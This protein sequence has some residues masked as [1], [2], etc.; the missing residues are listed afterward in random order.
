MLKSLGEYDFKERPKCHTCGREIS[1]KDKKAKAKDL[2]K[3]ISVVYCH[4][5]VKDEEINEGYQNQLKAKQAKKTK[6][7]FLRVSALIIAIVTWEFSQKFNAWG[8]VVWIVGGAVIFLLFAIIN[9]ML[10]VE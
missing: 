7:N 3:D 2:E 5:C 10:G 6:I 4:I 1:R 9:D 8:S